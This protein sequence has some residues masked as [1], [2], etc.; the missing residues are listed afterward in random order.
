MSLPVHSNSVFLQYWDFVKHFLN[1]SPLTYGFSHAILY[2]ICLYGDPHTILLFAIMQLEIRVFIPT[3]EPSRI[4]VF[5][6]YCT[7]FTNPYMIANGYIFCYIY[8]IPCRY[9]IDRMAII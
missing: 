5:F 7:I 4:V 9:I 3:T 6:Q 8:T 2:R 1:Q